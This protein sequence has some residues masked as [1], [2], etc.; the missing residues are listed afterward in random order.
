MS[1]SDLHLKQSGV[2]L[3]FTEERQ[4]GTRRSPMNKIKTG[5]DSGH[6]WRVGGD[7]QELAGVFAALILRG[8]MWAT[9]GGVGPFRSGWCR[10]LPHHQTFKPTH[11]H[12]PTS[13][14]EVSRRH[15][16][17]SSQQSS[18]ATQPA[19]DSQLWAGFL[20]CPLN[21][22]L[23]FVLIPRLV[24]LSGLWFIGLPLPILPVPST[25]DN[26]ILWPGLPTEP[27]SS[28]LCLV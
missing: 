27:Q 1:C 16:L 9:Q 19:P 12:V 10:Q 14:S 25:V 11:G 24:S 17:H 13:G 6:R 2:P 26:R 20:P 4:H 18:G 22:V 28:L 5:I 7:S 23:L 21:P 3:V 8:Q 15:P